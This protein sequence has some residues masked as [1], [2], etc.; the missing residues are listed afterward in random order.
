[1]INATAL[2]VLVFVVKLVFR[3]IQI[4]LMQQKQ[5]RLTGGK[6]SKVLSGMIIRIYCSILHSI[7]SEPLIKGI[8]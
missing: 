1:M 6:F 4:A 7:Q 5:I 2:V 3:C 8:F